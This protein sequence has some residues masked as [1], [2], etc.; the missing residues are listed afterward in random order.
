MHFGPKVHDPDPF[1]LLRPF[2]RWLQL[3]RCLARPWPCTAVLNL[4]VTSARAVTSAFVSCKR[5]LDSSRP[6]VDYSRLN[7]SLPCLWP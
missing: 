1:A 7:N 2:Q 4:R 3:Q 5:L 6:S